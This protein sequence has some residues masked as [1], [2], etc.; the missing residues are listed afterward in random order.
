MLTIV[1]SLS[2]PICIA[3]IKK[4]NN[5]KWWQGYGS[6]W[7]SQAL[8]VRVWN[9]PST[10]KNSLVV[11][12][13]IRLCIH[14]PYDPATLLLPIYPR[15]LK[16]YI[17]RVLHTN[18]HSSF[19][20][21]IQPKWLPAVE[22]I[23]CGLSIYNRVLLSHKVQTTDTC[24]MHTPHNHCVEWKKR[25]SKENI[26]LHLFETLEMINLICNDRGRS[27]FA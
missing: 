11:V 12:L 23:N 3:K 17:H 8:L 26:L 22:Q 9:G 2:V 25:D 7:N 14:L 18:V 13:Y 16:L 10:M 21:W 19:I 6:N 4:T 20:S 15:D 5:T 24:N 1:D 27:M